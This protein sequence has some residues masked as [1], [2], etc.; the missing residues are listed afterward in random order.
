MKKMK[1]LLFSFLLI[2]Q[3]VSGQIINFP[4]ANLKAKLLQS[5]INNKIAQDENNINIKIDANSDNEIQVSEALN[6]GY[7]DLSNA[8]ISDIT[9]INEFYNL[10]EINLSHNNLSSCNLSPNVRL[11]TIDCSNNQLSS[12]NVNGVMGL[13]GLYCS[14]NLL[15]SLDLSETLYLYYLY[16][17][18][19]QLT[20]LNLDGNTVL[21]GLNCQ[22]NL[23]THLVYNGST[24]TSL[25]CGDN[26]LTSLDCSNFPHLQNVYCPNNLLEYIN[27]KNGNRDFVT[28]YGNPTLKSICVDELP[29]QDSIWGINDSINVVSI[30]SY[31]SIAPGGLHNTITGKFIIDYDNNGCDENDLRG[32]FQH[33]EIQNNTLQ[34]NGS[35]FSNSNGEYLVYT[36]KGSFTLASHLENTNYFSVSPAD[37]L[38]NFE[39]VNETIEKDFC[40]T[41]NGVHPDLEVVA[42]P[43][44]VARPG[45][46]ATY[47]IVYKNKGNQ[48]LSG[49][50]GFNFNSTLMNFVSSSVTPTS[51]GNAGH[52][53]WA[54]TD[55]RPF[56]T[57]FL[58]ITLNINS[59]SATPAVNINDIL[60]FDVSIDPLTGDETIQDNQFTFNQTVV[61]AYDPN[62]VTCLE[63]EIVSPLEIGN[64]LHYNIEFENTGNYPAEN[65]VVKE[66]IDTAKYDINSIQ[67]LNSSNDMYTKIKGNVVEYYFENI[68]LAEHNHGNILLK[69]RSLKKLEAGDTV[70]KS[71]EIYFDYNL[72][73]LTNNEKTTYQ[74][75]VAG[76]TEN[77]E[78]KTISIF[79][80]PSNGVF[81]I[82][83]NNRLK[84]VEVFDI[85]GRLLMTKLGA[86]PTINISEK[87]AGVY[88]I[89]STSDKGINVSKVLK[90]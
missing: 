90:Q 61:G 7:L 36:E 44:R 19:N 22:N 48:M 2:S 41:A 15:T 28:I 34:T 3:I 40:I 87:E 35:I 54:F 88:F 21:V 74:Y 33:V 78:D 16:C 37:T 9:G 69:L 8:S 14:N 49:T 52:L 38:I 57:R 12:L 73:V 23:L 80:N 68:Q 81:T 60:I 58:D 70:S 85:N 25:D 75:L 79:P 65:I 84:S 30:N 6:V 47:Q 76:I 18:H 42:M 1:K 53:D 27:I 64:Y 29:V 71:A 89:K 24:L 67:I 4:D 82:Q 56:E 83:S 72:P 17:D 62:M 55:L 86:T 31:C 13:T 51:T 39:Y 11:T 43:I 63:G 59:P 50:V 32:G 46:D 20:E 45:F 77:G 10:H 5:A 26:K 66:V